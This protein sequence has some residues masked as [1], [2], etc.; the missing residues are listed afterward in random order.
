MGKSPKPLKPQVVKFRALA[1][2]IGADE[3]EAAFNEKL[4]KVAKAPKAVRNGTK[5]ERT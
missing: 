3:D 1:R 5:P 2:Q 4:K